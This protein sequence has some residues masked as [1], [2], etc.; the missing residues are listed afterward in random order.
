MG[1]APPQVRG[2]LSRRKARLE[3]MVAAFSHCYRQSVP[4]QEDRALG[5]DLAEQVRPVFDAF[6]D[7]KPESGADA[8]HEGLAL[9]TLLSRRAGLLGATPTTVLALE[10]ALQDGLRVGEAALEP[11]AAAQLRMVI[12]EGYVAG[13][14][15]RNTRELRLA[16]V[17]GLAL[18]PLAAQ[19]FALIAAGRFEADDIS[20]RLEELE[21]ELLRADARALL[22]DLTRLVYLSDEV[23]RVLCG[24]LATAR[25]L[26][27]HAF[28]CGLEE[29]AISAWQ[30]AGFSELDVNRSSTFEQA[31][32]KVLSAIGLELKPRRRWPAQLFGRRAGD[33]E[34]DP[35]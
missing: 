3:E 18:V 33:R 34:R 5:P 4:F 17:S 25:S 7:P 23:P 9:L 27:V 35:A 8:D 19:A 32:P 30:Q 11:R 22:L 13:R 15:E 21:R 28:V 2:N 31:L 26:G 1:G 24:V 16:A 6:S 20:P 14:D 29:H 10:A 12:L